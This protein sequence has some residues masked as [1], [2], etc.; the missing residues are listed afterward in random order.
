MHAVG[1]CMYKYENDMLPEL[2]KEMF[3]KVTGVFDHDTRIAT[4]KCTLQCMEQCVV[5]NPLSFLE[6]EHAGGIISRKI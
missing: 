5:R 1:F 6:W 4:T 2:F 3:V